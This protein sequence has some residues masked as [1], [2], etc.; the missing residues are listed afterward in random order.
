MRTAALPRG[1]SAVQRRQ[2]AATEDR[3]GPLG[4]DVRPWARLLVA[5]LDQEPLR[6]GARTGALEREAAVQLLTVQDEDGV[7]ALQR[8][9]PGD[10]AAL[11]VGAA[12]PHDHAAVADRPLEVVVGHAVVLDLHG[13]ALCG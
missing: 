2:R 8:L 10:T 7:A 6:L 3:L 1:R 9:R 13:Q 12:V 11:L 4:D 5:A